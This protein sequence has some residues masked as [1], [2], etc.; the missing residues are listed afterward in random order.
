M[1]RPP[2]PLPSHL[3]GR[4]FSVRGA[5]VAPKRLRASDVWAPAH[6]IRMPAG[7]DDMRAQLRARALRLPDGAVYSH[8][9]AALL[10]GLPLPHRHAWDGSVHIT[11]PRGVRA[12]RGRRV[13]GHQCD[14]PVED[15]GRLGDIP[16]TSLGRTFCDL[17]DILAEAE[18][19]AVGDFII[20]GR[21]LRRAKDELEAA[22]NRHTRRQVTLRRALAMLDARAESPKESEL[23]VL[24][25]RS[26]FGGLAT[27]VEVREP[28]GRFVARVDLAIPHLKI[29]IEYDGDHH[30]DRAQWRRDQQRR[31]RLEALGW[32]YIVVT[33]RDLDDPSQL[34]ADL[35]AAIRRRA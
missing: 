11:T 10:W 21:G 29:A 22:L 17:A 25:V 31:R 27:Q 32:I 15:V 16:A 8:A 24:L 20:A 3:Q 28:G 4:A 34:L 5:G 12:R 35:R 2:D 6:G 7:V 23:R 1:A 33:Q 26:G 18:L 14:L 13:R 9:T 30:R 19:V